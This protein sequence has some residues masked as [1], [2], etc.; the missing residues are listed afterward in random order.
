MSGTTM[1]IYV[2]G[3]FGRKDIFASFDDITRENVVSEVNKALVTHYENLLDEDY[4]YW[5][6]RG[7]TPVL[8]RTKERNQFVLNKVNV[9]IAEEIVTFKNGYFMTQPSFYVARNN[10]SQSKI[11]KLN[12]F[13]YRSGKQQADNAL[14]DWFHTVGKAALFIEPNDDPEIP[15]KA[16]AL[17]PRSAFVVYS[18]SP[19][20]KPVMGIH[21]VMVGNEVWI[22]VYTENKFFRLSG[23]TIGKVVTPIPNFE[24]TAISVVGEFSNVLGKIPIVEYRYN[25]VNMASFEQVIGLIDTASKIQSDRIDGLDQ[26]IQSLV[27]LYNAEMPEDEN[28][29]SLKRKGML[30]LKSSGENKADIKILSEQLDQGQTQTFLDSIYDQIYSICAM[31]RVQN[32]RTY[33]TTGAAV[34]ASAGWYQ[35]DAAARNC[36]DLF[37]ESN[38]Q[39][40]EIVLEI[41]K[42]KGILDILPSDFELHF[43]RNESANVQSK[44]QSFQ[45]LLAAGMHP[46]LA[47]SKSGVSNDPV[48]DIKRSE[49][50]LRMIWGDPDKVDEAEKENGGQ[51]EAEIIES[52]NFNGDNETGG[53]V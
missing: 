50:Y 51:G 34:M 19:G 52:D 17:D 11:D 45:T 32:G 21:T 22:D 49:K 35:A 26:F 43:I 27:V 10:A 47:A 28:A 53:S 6:R 46:E 29:D 31:P 3:L 5:Y 25:S 40:D 48:G 4:L 2:D 12:E 33:D 18:M 20:K 14:V 44:A 16:Y 13:L 24:S 7:V 8:G 15:Y 23:S 37:K 41:L 1:T 38:K 42:S 30:L 36:E 39:F 9:G